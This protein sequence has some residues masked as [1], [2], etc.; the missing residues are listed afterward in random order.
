MV[1]P[2]GCIMSVPS[3]KNEADGLAIVAQDS[4]IKQSGLALVPKVGNLYAPN[5][6]TVVPRPLMNLVPERFVQLLPRW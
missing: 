6:E 2:T 3:S 5:T 4:L 1:E